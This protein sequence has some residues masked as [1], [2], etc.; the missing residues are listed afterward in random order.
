MIGQ[1]WAFFV[2]K[3][4]F[5]FGPVKGFLKNENFVNDFQDQVRDGFNKPCTFNDFL[6]ERSSPMNYLNGVENNPEFLK[7]QK[8]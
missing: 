7:K 1:L 6:P 3:M 5:W 8:L 2:R 4:N